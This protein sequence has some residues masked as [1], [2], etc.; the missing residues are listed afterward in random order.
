MTTAAESLS[1]SCVDLSLLDGS[2]EQSLEQHR[3]P[4]LINFY[5]V[6]LRAL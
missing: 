1:K 6:T 2:G 5:R 3:Q 4:K